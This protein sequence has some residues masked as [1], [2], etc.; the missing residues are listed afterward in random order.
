MPKTPINYENACIYKICCKDTSI[1]DC[2]VGSTTNFKQRK[3]CHRRCCS[4]NNKNKDIKIYKFIRDNGEWDNWDMILVEKV[5]VNDVYELK[6]EER[7]WI[8]ELNATLNCYIPTRTKTEYQKEYNK[9]YYE[10]NKKQILEYNKE[11][12]KNNKEKIKEYNKEYHKNNKEKILEYH[13]KY[14]KNNKEKIKEYQK[15]W[16]ENNKKQITKYQKEYY[17]NNKEKKLEK[18]ECPICQC[19]ITKQHLKRHQKSKKCLESQN[20]I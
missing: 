8:E 7:K 13:K 5:N 19:V 17:E 3:N 4:D 10:N 16:Y 1:T 14:D 18:I 2:Y 15:E 11:Y 6:K 12:H 20:K 9:E